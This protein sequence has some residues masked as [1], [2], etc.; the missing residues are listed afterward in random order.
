M[1]IYNAVYHCNLN[2]IFYEAHT[3]ENFIITLQR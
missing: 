2:C 1:S 3:K